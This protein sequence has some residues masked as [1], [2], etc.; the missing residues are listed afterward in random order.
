MQITKDK[1][2]GRDGAGCSEPYFNVRTAANYFKSL[3]QSIGF[4]PAL[5]Q[6]NGYYPGMTYNVATAMGNDP[7]TCHFQQN[8]DYLSEWRSFDAL[9]PCT[10][11]K[12][13]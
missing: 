10:L 3:E 7:S 2:E 12:R 6:Y 8:L 11:M 5:G 4:L 13:S 1:C 9:L